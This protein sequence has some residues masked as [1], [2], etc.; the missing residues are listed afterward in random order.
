MFETNKIMKKTS[1]FFGA[2]LALC[3]GAV[4]GEDAMPK[5][6][7]PGPAAAALADGA[8]F[9]VDGPAPAELRTA[10][11]QLRTADGKTVWLQGLSVPSLEWLEGGDHIL[12][13]LATGI[14]DW[15][16][17][18]IRLPVRDDFWFGQ[19][20][21]QKDDGT[22]Y[23][24]LVDACIR[25]V[26]GRGAYVVLDLHR[27]KAPNEQH[28]RFWKEAAARYKN[29]PA[30]LFGLFNEPHE[31][32]WDV[33]QHGGTVE[34]NAPKSATAIAE[35]TIR[36]PTF[37]SPGMQRLVD[38]VRGTGA[39]NIVVVGGLDWAY[40][41][42]GVVN[43]H[44]LDDRGGNGIVYDT[45]IYPWKSQW[46]EKALVAAEK[47]PILVGEV[48]CTWQRMPFIPPERH[49]NPYTW[50]PDM[51]AFIQKHRLHWTA[52][53]FH[54]KASPEI[55]SNWEYAPT[56]YWGAFV[57]AALLGARFESDKVR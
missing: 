25:L 57:R 27:F 14:D 46:R 42:T 37:Q 39:K 28:L 34:E 21:G 18:I 20:K 41:L 9:I 53:S 55:I 10:G 24:K 51:I 40:D 8:A 29:H 3:A 12:Q 1:L 11:N 15:K 2:L 38:A 16:A 6:P 22:E 43:G 26:A 4:C 54:P 7:A 44:A 30:V 23:R 52:W 13:S 47:Y 31:I 5:P 49:E 33:W 32:S 56:P 19:G 48:G 17:N 35:N 36:H 45:H 50:A